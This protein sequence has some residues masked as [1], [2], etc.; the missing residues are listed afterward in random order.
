MPTFGAATPTER[1]EAMRAAVAYNLP[2]D[3][4][5]DN[6]DGYRVR[7][8]SRFFSLEPGTTS[9]GAHVIIEAPVTDGHVVPVRPGEPVDIYFRVNEHRY[10]Y[11]A[12]VLTRMDY[13]LASRRTARALRITYP[14]H[15]VRGQ[16]REYYRIAVPVSAPV[17][18]TY[19]VLDSATAVPILEPR[20]V[21]SGKTE[22]LN[23]SGGGLAFEVPM[24][25][26]L[27]LRVGQRIVCAFTLPNGYE[28]EMQGRVAN[29]YRI[30][31]RAVV[32]FGVEFID[33]EKAVDFRIAQDQ[34]LRYIVGVQR[35][36]LARRSGLHD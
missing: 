1:K 26:R 9:G 29:A 33:V 36:Q 21:Y 22:I 8:K 25:L 3:V 30:R 19:G 18:L 23:L 15:I 5:V 16:K 34:L 13:E 7:G 17:E 31:G 6:G 12:T 2:C 35:E 4:W 20:V 10:M 14:R 11:R 28:I 27:N 32:R 24:H